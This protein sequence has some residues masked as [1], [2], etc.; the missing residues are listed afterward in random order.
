MMQ[1][2]L[3]EKGAF[4]SPQSELTANYRVWLLPDGRRRGRKGARCG[5]DCVVRHCFLPLPRF[6]YEPLKF[7]PSSV[8]P[9]NYLTSIIKWKLIS[10]HTTP[11]NPGS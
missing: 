9:S 8:I 1:S 5:A 4:K 11:E 6:H 7:G 3:I 10:G 2:G